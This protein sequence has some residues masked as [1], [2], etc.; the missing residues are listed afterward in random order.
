MFKFRKYLSNGK[1]LVDFTLTFGYRD[2]IFF[3]WF[4]IEYISVD[5]L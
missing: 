4:F 5:I 2:N 1:Q 3:G